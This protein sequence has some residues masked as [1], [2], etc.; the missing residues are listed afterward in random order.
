[1]LCDKIPHVVNNVKE[2]KFLLVHCGGRRRESQCGSA[3]VSWEYGRVLHTAV[4][5]VRQRGTDWNWRWA[6]CSIPSTPVEV[7][8]PK[9]PQPSKT[10]PVVQTPQPVWDISDSNPN[11]VLWDDTVP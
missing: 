2:E 6:S 10:A 1:M 9:I 8:E 4:E 5:T 7:L 3:C 11:K